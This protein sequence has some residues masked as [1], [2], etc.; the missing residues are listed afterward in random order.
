MKRSFLAATAAAAM[1]CSGIALADGHEG[2]GPSWVPI[3]GFAC[4]F[5]DGKSMSDL[6]GPIDAYNDWADERGVDTYFATILTPQFFGERNFDFVWLG[7]WKDGNAMGADTELFRSEGSEVGA[8]F[9]EVVSCSSHTNFASRR[10]KAGPDSGDD[11]DDGEF[12]L[13]FSN[14][15]VSEGKSFEEA[16][17][18]LAAWSAY[19]SENGFQNSVYQMFPIYGESD[20]SYDFKMVEAHDN[21]LDF[22]NDWELMGNGGHWMKQMELVGGLLDCDISR[23]YDGR[24]VRDWADE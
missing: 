4:D 12:L 2:D 22:G 10:I 16:M 18:G 13:T 6:E 5:K 11:E 17:E 21:Y 14:C 19:Q 8:A 23:V 20:N 24:M 9:G 7:G 3:E 15:S 1:L